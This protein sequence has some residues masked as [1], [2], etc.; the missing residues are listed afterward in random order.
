VFAFTHQKSIFAPLQGLGFLYA[1][2]IGGIK[3]SQGK[4]LLHYTIA[5]LGGDTRAQMVM[6][7]RHWV[8]ITTSV[9]CERALD[10][11]RKVTK[12]VSEEVSLSGGP[13]VQRVRLLDEHENP[14]YTSG[15]FDQ[16]LI[17]YYQLLAKKG[18]TQAQVGLGQLHYQ[19]GRGVPLDHERAIQYF[20]H[21][22]DAGNPVAMAF[23]GKVKKLSE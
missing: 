22:A 2:G 5:A 12:K 8:G 17:E 21:A 18:D 11:Y 23:L 19:G 1:T 10:Y 3:A 13:V 14:G 6:G 9:S 7:Y 16:D 15:I 4:A 20:Q